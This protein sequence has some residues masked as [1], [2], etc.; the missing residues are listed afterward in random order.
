MESQIATGADARLILKLYDLRRETVLRKARHW[1][2]FEFK[3][4]T[5]EEFIAVWRD[6]P[7]DHSAWL[8]QVVTYWEMAA[9]FVL[10]GAVNAD[11]YLDSNGE[12]IA[13]YAKFQPLAEDIQ[14]KTGMPFM[15]HTTGMIEKFPA[16]KERYQSVLKYI[17]IQK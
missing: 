9:S 1:V 11:M 5:A 10:H 12:G 7:T 17:H 14:A 6:F 2:I 13:V 8:R 15:R 4:K 3:P 16:A